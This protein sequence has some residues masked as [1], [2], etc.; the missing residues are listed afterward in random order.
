MFYIPKYTSR[1]SAS[2]PGFHLFRNDTMAILNK[3]PMGMHNEWTPVNSFPWC[4]IVLSTCNHWWL[5]NDKKHPHAFLIIPSSFKARKSLYASDCPSLET[6]NNVTATLE[7]LIPTE[8]DDSATAVN[9]T[10]AVTMTGQSW[11]SLSMKRHQAVPAFIIHLCHPI[12]MHH[13]CIFSLPRMFAGRWLHP[14]GGTELTERTDHSCMITKGAAK[15][16]STQ[17]CIYFLTTYSYLMPA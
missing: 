4:E 5:C 15:I 11:L 14:Q 1:L 12:M 16:Y 3:K 8:D 9:N 10:R 2:L 17:I 6:G 7:M 13:I